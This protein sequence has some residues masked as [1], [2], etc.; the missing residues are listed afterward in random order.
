MSERRLPALGALKYFKVAAE[1]LS[2]KLAAE[3]LFV[4]QAAISQHIKTLESQLGCKLFV[5]KNREVSLTAQ[6]RLLLPYVQKGF[7]E[8]QKG[9]AQLEEDNHPNILKLSVLPSI[10]TFWLIPRLHLFRGE[11]PDLQVKLIPDPNVVAF[12]DFNLDLAIR[13][14]PGKYDNLSSR[15]LFP[16]RVL[17]VCHP[18]RVPDNVTPDDLRH[19]P[20]ITENYH[21]TDDAWDAFFQRYQLRKSDFKNHFEI[22][23]ATPALV[24][25]VLAGQGIAMVKQSLVQD[26]LASKQLI[27]LFGFSHLCDFAC[28]LVAP[29]FHFNFPK[30]IAFESWLREQAKSLVTA[31]SAEL[32][33]N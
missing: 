7:S 4:S 6:G 10:A 28:Y 31:M 23:D 16:D 13:F 12:D 33:S 9:I 1:T 2:F 18:H 25:A 24:G 26:Y 15:F 8:F 11:F 14:G 30:V 20:V 29:D 32:P 21:D 17:L 27:S 5:R 22:R 3:A 19:L